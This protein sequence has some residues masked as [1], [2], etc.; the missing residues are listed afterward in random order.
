MSRAF[1]HRGGAQLVGR[2]RSASAKGPGT[3]VNG[4]PRHSEARASSAHA[5]AAASPAARSPRTRFGAPLE[6]VRVQRAVA[7]PQR[8]TASRE[9]RTRDLHG[10]PGQ[11][12]A[13]GAARPHRYTPRPLRW[14]ACCRPTPRRPVRRAA[15]PVG[16]AREHAEHGE[17]P[18]LSGSHLTTIARDRYRSKYPHSQRHHS[19]PPTSSPF[20]TGALTPRAITPRYQVVQAGRLPPWTDGHLE[21]IQIASSRGDYDYASGDPAGQTQPARRPPYS[22][23]WR[24]SPHARFG[25]GTPPSCPAA[26]AGPHG[27]PLTPAMRAGATPPAFA[28]GTS[29]R[30]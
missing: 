22:G 3:P 8:V 10:A 28:S 24:P 6:L 13:P 17:L 29:P 4:W 19:Q 9:T 27:S 14:P 26:T 20:T 2:R 16:A 25:K 5:A 7:D 21:N 18:G 11:A 15:R 30:P 23:A 12:Q 1:L